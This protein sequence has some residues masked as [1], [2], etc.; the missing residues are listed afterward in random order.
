VQFVA[1]FTYDP[2]QSTGRFAQVT[3]GGFTMIATT[4]PFP[5]QIGADGFTPPFEYTWVGEGK[6]EFGKAK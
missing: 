5:L 3:G 1:E 6:I 4:E 2:E